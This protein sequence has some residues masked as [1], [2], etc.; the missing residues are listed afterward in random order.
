MFAVIKAGGHQYR[1]QVGDSLRVDSMTGEVGDAVR[2]E[3]VY[4]VNN[5]GASRIGT[6]ALAG[7]SVEAVIKSQERLPKIL[8]FKYKRRKN[9]KKSHGHKQPVTVVEIKKING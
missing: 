4:M 3:T 5:E 8:V 7:V 6:P 2:F 1:V 9:H